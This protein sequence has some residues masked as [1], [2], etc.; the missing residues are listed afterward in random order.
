MPPKNTILLFGPPGSGKSTFCHQAVLTNIETR[1]VIYVTTESAPSKVVDSLKEKGLGPV[2]PHTLS[3]VDA[4]HE[5]VGLSCEAR[6]DSVHASSEDLTGLSI[7][8]SKL[9]QRVGENL[10][11][12]FDS[13]TSPYLMRGSQILR[14][15]RMVL[16]KSAAEGNSVLACMDEG[17]GKEEDLVAMMS[18]ADGIIKIEL[19]NG[20]RTFNV[21]KH[22]QLG[23]AKIESPMTWSTA[24]PFR[25]DQRAATKQMAIS[26]GLVPGPAARK[27]IGDYVNVFWPNFIRWSSMLLDARRLPM[28][29]YNLNK[30]IASQ[31]GELVRN[32]PWR[33]R[34][35]LKF[36]PKCFSKVKDMKKLT[37]F[38]QRIVEGDR[39][40][41]FEYLENDSKTDEH[42]FR[43]Y[44]H[45]SCWGFECAGAALGLGVL[46]IYAGVISGFEKEPRDWN[47]IETRCTG[48]GDQYCEVKVVPGDIDGLEDSMMAIDSVI[49]ERIRD[50]LMERLMGF[51]LDGKPLWERPRLGDRISLNAFGH[52]VLPTVP[53]ERYQ[54][55]M[56]LGGAVGGKEV[57]ERLMGAGLSEDEA[58]KRILNLL[59]YCG[60]GKVTAA[61]T[62]RI[63]ENCESFTRRTESPSCQFT[64]GFLNGFFSAVKKQHVKET[65]CIAMGHPYCEWTFQ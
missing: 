48:R 8:I 4:F 49:V 11:L 17:C 28:L 10:L 40:F 18:M 64:T 25:I 39:S 52:I 20:S 19:R 27:E 30:H 9:Q 29:T 16:L 22:P 63:N 59:E 60:A 51:M 6:S 2:T 38:L 1:P 24:I 13:L 7:T 3:F 41:I 50:R 32:L 57:G 65:K 53:S 43:G 36:M 21:L 42:Y 23:P 35:L 26:M 54:T 55:A 34:F 31:M 33:T 47:I 44:E 61:E 37:L 12:I 46:G 56:R 14:F 62:I 58:E 45:A 15:M 5:T